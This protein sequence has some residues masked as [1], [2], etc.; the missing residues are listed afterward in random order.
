MS[1]TMAG[2]LRYNSWY[3]SLPNAAKQLEMTKFCVVWRLW[4]TIALLFF[5]FEFYAAF[6]VQFRCYT[7]EYKYLYSKLVISGCL[8]LISIVFLRFY[9]SVFSL[10]LIPIEKI[11]Q[12]LKTAFNHTSQ[13]LEVRKKYS[14]TRHIFSS[15]LGVSCLIY[16]VNCTHR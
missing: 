13:H 4:T 9:F 5:S 1:T 8:I 2:Y 10:V 7:L 3:L 6:Q 11:Y 14:A 16:Y 15:H 12:I